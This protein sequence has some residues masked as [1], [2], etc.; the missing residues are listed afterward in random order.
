MGRWE[1][2]GGEGAR[3]VLE[4]HFDGGA[5]GGFAHPDVEVF[6]FAGFEEEDVVAVVEVG[7]FVELV[8][9]GFRV[10]FGVFA[11][12]REEG[13]QVVEEVTMSACWCTVVSVLLEW[14]AILV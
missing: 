6:G 11:T 4:V 12:V 13:V 8:E 3:T 7:E 14:H 1:G 9:F 2:D 10:E 5:V